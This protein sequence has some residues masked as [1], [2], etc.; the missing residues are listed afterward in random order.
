MP[1]PMTYTVIKRRGQECPWC[2]KAIEALDIRGLSYSIRSPDRE[3]LI[4]I[5]HKA[6]MSTV[7]IIYRGEKLIG[8]YV[9]LMEHLK[10]PHAYMWKGRRIDE[11]SHVE[12]MNALVELGELYEKATQPDNSLQTSHG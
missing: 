7:P 10:T 5:A 4:C 8:G 1:N 12:L 2:D 3:E 11:M 6:G 9:E